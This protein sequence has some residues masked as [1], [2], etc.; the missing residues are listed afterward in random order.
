MSR[1]GTYPTLTKARYWYTGTEWAQNTS[2]EC[3]EQN[4]PEFVGQPL[5]FSTKLFPKFSSFLFMSQYLPFVNVFT[6]FLLPFQK[7]LKP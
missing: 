6:I 1:N 4:Q 2:P 3:Q 7:F 5:V